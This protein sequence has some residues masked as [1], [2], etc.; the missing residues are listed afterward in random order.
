MDL[1]AEL[2]NIARQR[3][4]QDSLSRNEKDCLRTLM[5]L[6]VGSVSEIKGIADKDS[7]G[8]NLVDNLLDNKNL[9]AVIHQQ[10]E[11]LEALK[12]ISRNLATRLESDEVL[13]GIVT[14]AMRL[15][16]NA[17]D[18]HIFLY[19]DGML[20][21]GAALDNEGNHNHPFAEPRPEGLTYQV[22]RS[23]QMV[24]VEDQRKHP[25]F[26]DT[27]EHWKGSIVAIPLMM[28]E[29]VVGV[30]NLARLTTGG[31]TEGEIRLLSLLADQAAIAIVNARLHEAVSR[32][33]RSDILTG[34]PNRR[35]LDERLEEEVKLAKH[36]D[37]PLSVVMMDMDG[38]KRINDT[39]GHVVGDE[40]LAKAFAPLGGSIRSSDFLARYG[41]DELTLVLPDTD[42]PAANVVAHKL[43]EQLRR[44]KILLPNRKRAR[45]DLSGGIAMYPLH[46]R[47]ASDLLRAADEAL[48]RAKKNSR[49][50]FFVAQN[51]G[52]G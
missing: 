3:I 45:L 10:T 6:L 2:L 35:A 36:A 28:G 31:F 42:I 39:F 50:Q 20:S 44:T 15:I 37:H 38:F 24:V 25:L 18:A 41:G 22:A 27:P 17:H 23:R 13:T 29:R 33:A 48:P 9:L 19:H 49:G 14:E 51:G 34:L 7:T 4:E 43:Q 32:Q 47:S 8:K 5:D 26:K 12:R 21:F 40:I 30:M 52:T 11:E 46:G 16:K 1:Q